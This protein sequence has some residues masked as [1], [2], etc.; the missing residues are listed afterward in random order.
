MLDKLKTHVLLVIA[1][2]LG[3]SGWSRGQ[4]PEEGT[5]VFDVPDPLPMVDAERVEMR[6][7]G[8]VLNLAFDPFRLEERLDERDQRS[9]YVDEAPINQAET[10]ES[11]AAPVLE[12]SALL[13]LPGGE[14]MAVLNG[15]HH[16]V[17]DVLHIGTEGLEVR[18]VRVENQ[19]VVL[20]YLDE[21]HVLDVFQ[22]SR[23]SLMRKGAKRMAK[24]SEAESAAL[25]EPQQP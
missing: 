19:K 21:E 18:L 4:D 25:A 17:G 14:S 20:S 2:L 7:A 11:E 6:A 22:W 5:G 10:G 1:L 3:Y 15:R 16:R 9:D 24:V 12:L 23:L 13:K 8:E